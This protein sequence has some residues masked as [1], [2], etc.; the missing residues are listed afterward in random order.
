VEF[1]K[2][3]LMEVRIEWWIPEVGESRGKRGMRKG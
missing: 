1:L 2:N 3:H